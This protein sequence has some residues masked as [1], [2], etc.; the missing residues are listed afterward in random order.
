MSSHGTARRVDLDDVAKAITGWPRRWIIY[1]LSRKECYER[2]LCDLLGS[3]KSSMCQ[4]LRTL[5]QRGLIACYEEAG[6]KMCFLTDRTTVKQTGLRVE[7]TARA[8]DGDESI[9]RFTLD[10]GIA[11]KFDAFGSHEA[12]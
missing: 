10:E 3:S 6:R 2:E 1:A 12:A 5:R 7:I 9:A 8:P 4:D 11:A